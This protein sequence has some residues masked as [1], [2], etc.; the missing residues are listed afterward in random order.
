MAKASE[1]EVHCPRC[2]V[3]FPVGTKHC[4]HCGGRTGP[5]ARADAGWNE[6]SGRFEPAP[7]GREGV[8]GEPILR[9][10]PVDAEPEEMEETP[11]AGVLRAGVT[12]LWIVLAIGF[13][14]LRACSER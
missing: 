10:R 7:G 12:L 9:P 11:R 4:L 13:S 6:S 8:A 14:I 3:T 1:Y 5:R 2:N